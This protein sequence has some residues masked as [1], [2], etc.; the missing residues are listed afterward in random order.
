MAESQGRQN[1]A[2]EHEPH[3]EP[4][5]ECVKA[6]TFTMTWPLGTKL[7]PKTWKKS[8]QF[9][10][11]RKDP[12][13]FKRYYCI[14]YIYSMIHTL[15]WTIYNDKY[16]GNHPILDIHKC[17]FVMTLPGLTV[18]M[19]CHGE[20]LENHVEEIMLPV[21]HSLGMQQATWAG[22]PT[23][24]SSRISPLRPKSFDVPLPCLITRGWPKQCG[25]LLIR[26]LCLLRKL[27]FGIYASASMLWKLCF[28]NCASATKH[29]KLCF[30]NHA[31][32][33]MLP[34]LCL[35]NNVLATEKGKLCCRKRRRLSATRKTTQTI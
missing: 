6:W 19:I 22:T 18:S 33:T 14:H 8:L 31:S 9:T 32:E 29:S 2:K 21:L 12:N 24:Y 35:G 4:H 7:G 26:K 11:V 27:C 1:G 17:Q 5:P 25:G 34:K 10:A 30:G 28:H 20:P 15:E 16:H 23:I 3:D 13:C